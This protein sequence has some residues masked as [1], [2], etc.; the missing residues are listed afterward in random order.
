MQRENLV[1]VK[2]TLQERV[3]GVIM[4]VKNSLGENK[5]TADTIHVIIKQVMELVDK[6]SIPGKEKRVYV[7]TIVKELVDDLA[8]DETEIK[9]INDMIEKRVLEN[10]IDLIISASKGDFD[11]NNKNTQEKIVKY[12]RTVVPLIIQFFLY[13]YNSCKNLNKKKKTDTNSNDVVIEEIKEPAPASAP[14]SEPASVPASEPASA[15][16]SE[17]APA[18]A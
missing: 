10:T 1:E 9:L 7:V 2:D 11:I 15:P 8:E 6:F 4:Q 3:V 17:P 16:A 18:P 13:L 12:V 5:I 14:A